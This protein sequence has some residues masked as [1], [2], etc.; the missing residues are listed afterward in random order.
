MSKPLDDATEVVN[1]D[2]PILLLHEMFAFTYENNK[3]K[4]YDT[5]VGGGDQYNDQILW[6]H[7]A[8][9]MVRG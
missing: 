4:F 6:Q 3:S 1:G 9:I 8:I 2:S 7:L 5:Y